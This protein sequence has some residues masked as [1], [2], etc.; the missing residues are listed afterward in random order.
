[1]KAAVIAVFALLAGCE[2]ALIKNMDRGLQ[3]FVGKDIHSAITVLGEP[4]R[5]QAIAGDTV[6]TWERAIG[7]DHCTLHI[8]A[9]SENRVMR[10]DW[11][12]AHKVCDLYDDMLNP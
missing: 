9:D 3:A 5:Q 4:N 2:A 8:V 10:S 1:M 6:Y 12:G 11:N 7:D